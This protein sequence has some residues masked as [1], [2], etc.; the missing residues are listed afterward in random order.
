VAIRWTQ[1]LLHSA[2]DYSMKLRTTQTL[3]LAFR[4]ASERVSDQ[5]R[6]L[7]G[8]RRTRAPAAGR[9]HAWRHAAPGGRVGFT[10]IELLV[11]LA[12]IGLLTGLLLPAVQA[13]RQAARRV[14]CQ[15]NLRQI[16]LGLNAYHAAYGS[17]P[18]GG[19]EWRPPGN[20]RNR[21]L[22]WSALLLPF[23]QEQA[24]AESLDLKTPFDSP[25]NAWGAAQVVPV[26]V[27]PASQRGARLVRGRGPCDY[28]G[29]H[30]ERITSPNSPPKGVMLYD[31]RIKLRDVTDG[32]A[33]TVIVGE[34][35]RFDD[36]QWINGRN[37][38]D[39]AF[40]INA[41]PDFENDIRSEHGGGANVV[42]CDG[43][44]HFLSEEMNLRV[45]AALCTRAGGEMI[46]KDW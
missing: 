11:V 19:I 38:F 3:P 31:E 43:S 8:M 2:G 24:L 40:A 32:A 25:E 44:V 28:G 12:I 20:T 37:I 26:Y 42:L 5:A 15:N 29:I 14:Q 13:S 45:L 22:A 1:A 36:G 30:G 16:G 27:C 41:A 33:K 4:V 17:Y 35:S 9:R 6:S 34:D 10:L 23:V 7:F 46:T 18:P 21:Q 39:Q